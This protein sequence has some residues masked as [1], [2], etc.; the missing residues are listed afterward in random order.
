M[1]LLNCLCCKSIQNGHYSLQ[2]LLFFLGSC[3][4]K[5]AKFMQSMNKNL[6]ISILK[7]YKTFMSE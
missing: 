4:K 6:H 3:K 1:L 7:L 2:I 5:T